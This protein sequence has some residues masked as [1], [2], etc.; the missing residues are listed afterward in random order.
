MRL[1]PSGHRRVAF[2]RRRSQVTFSRSVAR[3][4]FGEMLPDSSSAPLLRRTLILALFFGAVSLSCFLLYRA[5]DSVGILFPNYFDPTSR[6][7]DVFPS[8]TDDSR[9]DSDEYRLESILKDAAMQDGTVIL[10]TLNEAW[11]A[12]NS[13]IDLF[14]ESFRIGDRTRKL[15]NHLVIIALDKKAFARCLVVHTH[16]FALVT[17]GIDFS[18]EAYFMTPDYL[19][20]MWRRID[21]L[22]SVLEMGYN[23]VFTDADIMWFRD[24]FPHFYSDADFQ[25]A[26]D[27]FSGNSSDNRNKPNGGFKFVRSNNRS[28]EFYK[29]WYSKRET[30]PE[31]HD[32]DV[33]NNIKYDS[34]IIDI[35]LK[36]RFLN[37]AYF[38]GLCEPSKDFNQ[39]CTMHAN[40][41]FGLDSKLHDL[42]IM[43]QDWKLYMSLPLSLKRSLISTWRVPHNCSLDALRHHNP[44]NKDVER[45]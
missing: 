15:L 13:I 16:C 12:P 23:F 36:M 18:Q 5:S 28:I 42:R 14:L 4:C 2:L 24:P 25:I 17:K 6:F 44:L 37:T 38:G 29:F 33:L 21:F 27:S 45:G 20:M 10:T 26:C 3:K 35:D 1:K 41:C 22:R 9:L 8:I 43:L 19:K 34:F 31:Y 40:C 30:Y 7:R 39:V 32:Q 11:A